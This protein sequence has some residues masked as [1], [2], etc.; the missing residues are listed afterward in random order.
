MNWTPLNSGTGVGDWSGWV[1]R[2]CG[3][4]FGCHFGPGGLIYRCEGNSCVT[5]AAAEPKAS[6]VERLFAEHRGALQT[7]FQRRIRTKADAADL[8][9]EV[10]VRMLA[11]QL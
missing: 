9:Q 3:K 11:L 10:Y 2:G 7:F 8:A 4:D 5:M 1:G 6:L